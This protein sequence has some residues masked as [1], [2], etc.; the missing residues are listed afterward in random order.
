MDYYYFLLI[1]DKKSEDFLK[2]LYRFSNNINAY[3]FYRIFVS[4]DQEKENLSLN[5]SPIGFDID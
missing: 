5:I 3:S 1:K 2:D 4:T